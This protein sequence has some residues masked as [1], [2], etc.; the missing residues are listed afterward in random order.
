NA[1]GRDVTATPVTAGLLSG[2]LERQARRSLTAVRRYVGSHVQLAS[3]RFP[4]PSRFGRLLG[5]R[6]FVARQQDHAGDAQGQRNAPGHVRD[7]SV[8][9]HGVGVAG[10]GV[11]VE[12]TLR[13]E[14]LESEDRP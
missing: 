3:S 10:G 9:L 5:G 4:T 8:A 11:V 2:S 12:V 1:T 7:E 13:A 6:R 14:R